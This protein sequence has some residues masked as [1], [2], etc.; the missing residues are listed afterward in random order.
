MKKKIIQ[1][2]DYELYTIALPFDFKK[3]RRDSFITREL[4]KLHPCYSDSTCFDYTLSF[5]KGKL[6]ANVVVMDSVKLA[7]YKNKG[8][9]RLELDEIKRRYVFKETKSPLLLLLLVTSLVSISFFSVRAFALPNSDSSK[10]LSSQENLTLFEETYTSPVEAAKVLFKILDSKKAKV[11]SYSFDLKSSAQ[12][13]SIVNCLPE[14]FDCQEVNNL[15]ATTLSFSPVSYKG[16]SSFCNLEVFSAA[17]K[18]TLAFEKLNS[19]CMKKIRR[20]LDLHCVKKIS[21]DANTGA[22]SFEIKRESVKNLFSSLDSLFKE[23]KVSVGKIE[24][25]FDANRAICSLTLSSVPPEEEESILQ[26]L[27]S[28]DTVFPQKERK[29]YAKAEEK[30][31]FEKIGMIKT[32][33]GKS[34]SYYKTLEG[35]IREVIE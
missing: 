21:D 4:E 5:S 26:V 30:K 7:E 24:I 17:S 9:C 3:K 10:S 15:S 33:D 31:S 14:D 23:D 22:F 11:E 34:I 29:S 13:F 1:K 28:V 32:S 8:R 27:S 2:K 19:D 6:L 18:D 20:Q 12:N 25:S 16:A 35:K